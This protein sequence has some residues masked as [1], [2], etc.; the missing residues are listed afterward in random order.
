[1]FGK[2]AACSLCQKAFRVRPL[3]SKL[4]SG[5]ASAIPFTQHLHTGTNTVP[6]HGVG[7]SAKPRA[8]FG[9][10]SKSA[11][12]GTGNGHPSSIQG[13]L[14]DIHPLG[15][16]IVVMYSLHSNYNDNPSI[17]TPYLNFNGGL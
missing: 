14:S 2:K 6:S 10:Y 11:L 13:W 4:G 7:L 15:P 8:G 5:K 12:R 16:L 1:M 17:S 9:V 3:A